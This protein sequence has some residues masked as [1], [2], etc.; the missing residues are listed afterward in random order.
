[1]LTSLY[2]RRVLRLLL[3]RNHLF[4]VYISPCSFDLNVSPIGIPGSKMEIE[5]VPTPRTKGHTYL[6]ISDVLVSLWRFRM[7]IGAYFA[8]PL[9]TSTASLRL[10]SLL[11]G[12]F[13][14][15][16]ILGGLRDPR[17]EE[18]ERFAGGLL[19]KVQGVVESVLS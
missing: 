2:R 8:Y 1:M 19:W 9:T 7:V 13:R 4:T 18:Y 5:C 12:I 15:E 14:M 17:Y 16:S 6:Y 11:T 3:G 10:H